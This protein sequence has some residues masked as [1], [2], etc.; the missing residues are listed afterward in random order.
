MRDLY[1]RLS[2]PPDAT[3]EAIAAAIGKVSNR[4]LRSD[5]E[6]VLLDDD[7]RHQY[8]QSYRVLTAVGKIR[9]NLGLQHTEAWKAYATDFDYAADPAP[10]KED[11]LLTKLG[12]SKKSV[13]SSSQGRV[14]AGLVKKIKHIIWVYCKWMLVV[15]FFKAIFFGMIHQVGMQA[16]SDPNDSHITKNIP[17]PS[18]TNAEDESAS[19]KSDAISKSLE[20]SSGNAET[21]SASSDSVSGIP[22]NQSTELT[23]IKPLVGTNLVLSRAN[24]RW[25]LRESEILDAIRP[26]VQS[27]GAVDEFNGRIDNYN[28]R[29]ASFQY[30]ESTMIDAK[31][32]VAPL[33]QQFS[34]EGRQMGLDIESRHAGDTV[35]PNS[36]FD[37]TRRAQQLLT[38]L[39]YRPGPIDGSPG[40]RTSAALRA[41]QRDHDLYPTGKITPTLLSLLEAIVASLP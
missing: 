21:R 22:A 8:H 29:C 3:Q 17:S 2:V 13:T 40:P 15:V 35:G 24:I 19:A 33:L 12:Q 23:Y 41:F 34:D 38:D 10:S 20:E 32:D 4:A 37:A 9:A 39:G 5:C 30:L 25:C 7:H 31:S 6:T 28:Q 14:V 11:V 16:E 26:I 1:S 27:R 36:V 18:A